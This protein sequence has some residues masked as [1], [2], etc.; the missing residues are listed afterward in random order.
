ME[1]FSLAMK[2][3]RWILS[4][5]GVFNYW[6]YDEEYFDFY[7]GRMLIRG[8][9]GAG[10]S[11]TMQSFIPLL[12]DGNYHPSR[13]DSF[14][15]NA[16]KLEDYLLGEQDVSQKSESTGYL[17]LEF[18]KENIFISI[19]MGM[20]AKR[21]S[22]IDV[23]YFVL[24]D[25][26]RF[27]IDIFFYE[28]KDDQ[29]IPLTKKKFE[30]L[31]GTGGKVFSSRK[32]YAFE[33][34]KIL[35]GFEQVDD[36]DN[37]IDL[38]L[39]I[40]TPKLSRDIKPD[41]ICGVLQESLPA[42]SEDD[43][44]MLSDSIENLDRI[45][46][47]LKNLENIRLALEKVKKAYDEY[48]RYLLFKRM[49]D[50]VVSSKSLSKVKKEF[51]ELSSE[52]EKLCGEC[53]FL[54]NQLDSIEKE[55]QMLKL[56]VEKIKESDIYRLES[57]KTKI[58]HEL[59]QLEN[60]KKS[61]LYI[62]NGQMKKQNDTFTRLEA[63]K[64][65]FEESKN[66][67]KVCIEQSKNILRDINMQ[68]FDSVLDAFEESE[69]NN[70][71]ILKNELENFI[72]EVEKALKYYDNLSYIQQDLDEQFKRL[73]KAKKELEVKNSELN[74]I[75]VQLE[76]TKADL[77]SKIQAY[78]DSNQVL[79]AAQKDITRMFQVINTLS[80]KGE[81]THV[82]HV[83]NEVY[84]EH[85][86]K[87][88]DGIRTLRFEIDNL[89]N[90][91][92]LKKDKIDEIA[93]QKDEFIQSSSEQRRVRDKLIEK[94]I[95]FIPFYMAVD[96]KKDVKDELK[97][98]IEDALLE[99]GILNALIV[100]EKYRSEL[101]NLEED[102]KELILF[103][104]PVYFSQTMN[105][106][107]EVANFENAEGLKEDVAAV[108]DSI[109]INPTQDGVYVCEDGRF[110][111]G[112]LNGR[113]TTKSNARFIGVENR[114]R[115]KQMLISQLESE[116]ALLN[117]EIT[118]KKISMEGLKSQLNMLETEKKAFPDF[119]DLDTAFEMIEDVERKIS[120]LNIDIERT[121][122]RI[123]ELNKKQN[124][125]KYEI[126][127]ISTKL[128]LQQG[129]EVFSKSKQSANTLKSFIYS[130]EKE[131]DK[132]I[133]V[134]NNIHNLEQFSI[135]L[136]EMID[137]LNSE[138]YDISQKFELLSIELEEIKKR[139][140]QEDAKKLFEEEK[141]SIERL[142]I[143]PDE[144]K[145]LNHNL[146]DAIS[147][148]SSVEQKV[149]FA[150][151][152]LEKMKN[153]YLR[154][155]LLLEK[156]LSFGF[157]IKGVHFE[158]D[159]KL[160]EFAKL[161]SEELAEYSQ[162]DFSTIL[163][164]LMSTHYT[165]QV[166]LS[167]FGANLEDA[168]LDEDGQ[169]KRYIL[170]YKKEGRLLSPYQ[171]LAEVE[172]DIEEKKNLITQQERELFEEV[173][174]KHVGYKI[175]RKIMLA[176]DWVK[177]MNELMKELSTSSGLTF[178]LGWVQKPLEADNELNTNE[179]V[180]LLSKDP[181]TATDEDRSKIA[182]HFKSRIERAKKYQDNPDNFAT[183]FEL[184][185]QILDYRQWFEFRLYYQKVGENRKELT[186]NAFDKFSGGEKALSIYVPLLVALCAKYQSA[187]SFAPR[188]IVLDEAFAGVD[189][190][191]IENMFDLI[192][193]L[194]FDYIMNS[195]FLWGD[196]RTVPGLCIYE[197]LHE[198]N[199]PS[200]L[201]VKYIWN[202]YKKVLVEA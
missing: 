122:E 141:R 192:E 48:N 167:E 179:L 80:Q 104:K 177:R 194:E 158:D 57:Q 43:L 64:K 97:A 145:R 129:K 79:K 54:Q 40:R 128:G 74:L 199:S 35:F 28:L 112:I 72:S 172:T 114:R 143:I 102:E 13:L 176:H 178:H 94:G 78:F 23:W 131:F 61:K 175:S 133:I 138:I 189:E 202:G 11:V 39:K 185:K 36:F 63:A 3:N 49:V 155:K 154:S 62:L 45:Q 144:R 59:G 75:Q 25:N 91:V 147:K 119:S 24:T 16:R 71:E 182:M 161:K 159:D 51:E 136:K 200:V 116:I 86:L 69:K 7:D 170:S 111:N 105:Y 117:E 184:I 10:K 60:Q 169:E 56:R 153:N 196:Y 195:Q 26:R 41:K 162:K 9:N 31:I 66:K 134:L 90:E 50:F 142:N 149:I 12:L 106:Y 171:L 139:L 55:E 46:T 47:E 198:N 165:T 27:G 173:L 37:L 38:M 93:K 191:N 8:A 42:L 150:K 186:N 120:S 146:Q 68:K 197:L 118:A 1:V 181:L 52:H 2:Q 123:K 101:D 109:Q 83:L 132:K 164:R 95:P 14:G 121:E 77:K 130:L 135:Q 58:E 85:Y 201:K 6:Y 15:S 87:I 126:S 115:Y 67:I 137:N 168:N 30:N 70:L 34:N 152:E 22:Q 113:T 81:S 20:R 127:L 5:A 19:G 98:I 151:E 183:L 44:R 100:P 163:E 193:K 188:I 29:K 89:E 190:N 82:L 110:G 125:L 148:R 53:T 73:D 17:F 76:D 160:L 124:A 140:S 157:V 107:L 187:A 32:D 174:A 99:L 18:K 92:R 156:E 96:F 84:N 65:E 103:P 33:V 4:R 21:G 180:N 108:I 166:I 88:S